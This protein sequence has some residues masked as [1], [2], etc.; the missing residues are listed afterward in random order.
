MAQTCTHAHTVYHLQ[1]FKVTELPDRCN[2]LNTYNSVLVYMTQLVYHVEKHLLTCSVKLL[3][4]HIFGCQ[5]A[6]LPPCISPQQPLLNQILHHC[7]CQRRNMIRISL[8]H[9]PAGHECYSSK[10]YLC[11]V[12][13]LAANQSY[14]KMSSK[15]IPAV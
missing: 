15:Y 3:P 5:L 6:P 14:T 9:R 13:K 10:R 8:A 7:S 1:A 11:C 4:R 2:L 12:I